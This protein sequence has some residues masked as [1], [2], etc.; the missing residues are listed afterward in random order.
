FLGVHIV[1][2]VI[3]PLSPV[4]IA[5]FIVPFT[6][7][8][9]PLAVGLG[10]VAFDLLAALVITS[11]LRQRIGVRVWRLIHWSAYACWPLAMLHGLTAGTDTGTMWA[12]LVYLAGAI[13][14]GVSLS[15]RLGGVALERPRALPMGR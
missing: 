6:G 14:V 13:L 15:W 11:L 8:Y 7:G 3:D 5:N 4:R 10:V 12:N 9:R 1:T 2:S